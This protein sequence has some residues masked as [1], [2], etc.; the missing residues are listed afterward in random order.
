MNRYRFS[1]KQ[2]LITR[3]FSDLFQQGTRYQNTYFMLIYQVANYSK[4]GISIP[5]KHLPKSTKRNHIKRLIREQ[6][7]LNQ[8]N[9]RFAITV[10][11]RAK[12]HIANDNHIKIELQTCWDYLHTKSQV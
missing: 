9:A 3:E 4:L 2:K 5:K 6:F 1:H 8:H 11:S 12:I 7:R 10:C